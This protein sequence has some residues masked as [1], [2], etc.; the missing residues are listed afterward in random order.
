MFVVGFVHLIVLFYFI[1]TGELVLFLSLFY[2]FCVF[3]MLC[4]VMRRQRRLSDWAMLRSSRC[5]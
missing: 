1:F 3:P 2:Y 4:G 5:C